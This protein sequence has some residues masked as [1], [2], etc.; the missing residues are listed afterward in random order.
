MFPA[1]AMAR[2]SMHAPSRQMPRF[3]QD[4]PL[5]ILNDPAAWQAAYPNRSAAN[6]DINSDGVINFG[7]INPLVALLANP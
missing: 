3:C 2:S 4:V 1:A 6:S 7:D 5:M